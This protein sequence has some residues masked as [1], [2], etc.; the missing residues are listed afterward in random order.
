MRPYSITPSLLARFWAK[1]H[2]LPEPDGCW[3]W[4]GAILTK[5]Y[6]QFWVGG[7]IKVQAHR[8]SWEI[9]NGPIP[10]G[11]LAC[12]SCDVK[13]PPG[14]ITYRKCVRPSHLFLGTE[15]DNS[16]DA[17]QKGRS[18][19]M[20]HPESQVRGKSVGSSKLTEADVMEILRV[21]D[22]SK[23]GRIA[24]A[25]QYGV[26]ER[27]IQYILSRQSWRHLNQ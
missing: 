25:V 4:T 23:T 16:Q 8:I 1:V 26:T 14:D 22:G 24:L 10:E 17:H 20:S 7:G 5:G 27:M 11:L 19:N 12:H 9:H 3:E 21:C 13:Y 6:G 18:G 15:A 2:K